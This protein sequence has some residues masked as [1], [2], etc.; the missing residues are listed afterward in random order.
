MHYD[1]SVSD[2]GRRTVG[3]I[4]IA[5]HLDSNH[6]V[7]VA[8]AVLLDHITYIVRFPRLLKLPSGHEILDLSD[9]PYCVSMRL[10]QPENNSD[11]I[12]SEFATISLHHRVPSQDIYNIFFTLIVIYKK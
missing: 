8:L 10:R 3:R 6:H 4:R 2:G 5:A 12:F 9:R 1:A 7:Q 11:P